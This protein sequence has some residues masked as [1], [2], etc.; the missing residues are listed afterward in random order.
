[1]MQPGNGYHIMLVGL[2]Q[3]LKLGD[4]FSLTL[5]FEKAGKLDVPVVVEEVKS[6]MEMT[7]KDSASHSHK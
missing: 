3:P 1:V 2:K 7:D 4:K 5:T 6:G